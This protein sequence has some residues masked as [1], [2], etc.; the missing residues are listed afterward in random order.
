MPNKNTR[1]VLPMTQDRI[2]KF[3]SYIDKKESDQCWVWTGAKSTAGYGVFLAKPGRVYISSHRI[4]FALSRNQEP[5]NC[6]CHT[7][8]NPPCCNPDHLFDG[9]DQDNSFDM[10][11]KGRANNY[12][13]KLTPAKVLEIRQ[14]YP[15]PQDGKHRPLRQS[16]SYSETAK[17]YG[18]KLLT[19]YNV[20]NFKTWRHV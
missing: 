13:Q 8:D 10:W 2:D 16:P 14:L 20:A 5:K 15:L 18:V 4:A 12:Q 17:K 11:R 9:S 7:C 19:I 1:P 6:I 3:W